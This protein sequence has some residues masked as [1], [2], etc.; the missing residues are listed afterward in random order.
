M[1]LRIEDYALIGD[2]QT[3][4]LVAR[5]GS[6]DWLCLPR[7]D[8]GTCF[9]A[10]LGTPEHGRWL[11]APVGGVRKVNRHYRPGTL[12]LETVFETEDGEVAV[13]DFMPPRSQVPELIRV[14]EGRRGRVPMHLELVI[15]FDYGSII[16]WVRDLDRGLS[17]IAGPDRIR[18]RTG[19]ELHGIDYRTVAEFAVAEGQR[20]IF[21]LA[22][23]PTHL[24]EPREFDVLRASRKPSNGGATGQR[25]ARTRVNGPKRS[26][27]R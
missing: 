25:D 26:P 14:V 5:D 13:I 27:A 3:A 15:R 1:P 24:P 4:A 17:A 20:E 2:C 11:I 8:S 23:Q 12:V 22:W 9:A 19:V 10:L 18:L 21:E 16:P 7:F 6:I